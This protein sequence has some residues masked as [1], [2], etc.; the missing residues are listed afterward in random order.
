[1][2]IS[3]PNINEGTIDLRA[4]VSAVPG[5]SKYLLFEYPGISLKIV[6]EHW[7]IFK[8]I[9][10]DGTVKCV[11]KDYAEYFGVRVDIKCSWSVDSGCISM[12]I[13]EVLE[14]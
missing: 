12:D 1:M 13:V 6:Q 2:K 14:S 9:S 5:A 7:I 8:N 10:R 4:R 11:K 3:T